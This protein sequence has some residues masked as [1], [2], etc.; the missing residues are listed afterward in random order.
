MGWYSEGRGE[1]GGSLGCNPSALV[2]WERRVR[3]APYVKNSGEA[4]ATASSGCWGAGVSRQRAPVLVTGQGP[5]GG[6][7]G[8]GPTGPGGACPIPSLSP[9]FPPPRVLSVSPPIPGGLLVRGYPTHQAPGRRTLT[10]DAGSRPLPPLPA[11]Q[12]PPC[13]RLANSAPTS[14]S[15]RRAARAFTS[16]G[17]GSR[18]PGGRCSCRV[19]QAAPPP[20]RAAPRASPAQP[21]GPG[22]E[23]RPR[24]VQPRPIRAAPGSP[25]RG[26]SRP[27]TFRRAQ[28]THCRKAFAW[29]GGGSV[30][31][32][33]G[34]RGEERRDS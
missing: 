28:L 3:P 20:P 19:L 22:E 29:G 14:L 26:L 1:S 27:T 2:P 33:A 4:G 32:G 23:P 25:P 12:I 5:G 8:K 15:W 30:G 34:G 18:V 9:S 31:V 10:R 16:R 24:P 7:A 13:R 17:E 6:G 21:P 11:P